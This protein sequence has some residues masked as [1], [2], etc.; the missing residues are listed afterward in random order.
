[1]TEGYV[2]LHAASA[3]SFLKV[4]LCPRTLSSVCG[5][6]HAGYGPAGS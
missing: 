6:Q 1:M 4:L 3:F 5:A 2:E